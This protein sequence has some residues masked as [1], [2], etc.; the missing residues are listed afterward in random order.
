MYNAFYH[1]VLMMELGG[2]TWLFMPPAVCTNTGYKDDW[3]EER[4]AY[5]RQQCSGV[6]NWEDNVR[7]SVY[8]SIKPQSS[9]ESVV[10][11]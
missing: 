3:Q 11:G 2:L 1:E 7:T 8:G 9:S 6:H 10:L 5:H 4:P